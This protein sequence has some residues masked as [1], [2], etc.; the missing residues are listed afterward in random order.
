M[1]LVKHFEQIYHEYQ[2]DKERL[3]EYSLEVADIFA[4]NKKNNLSTLHSKKPYF[5]ESTL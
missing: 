5:L 3:R 4:E 1:N 2:R